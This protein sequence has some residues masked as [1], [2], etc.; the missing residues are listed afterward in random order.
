MKYLVRFAIVLAV[1]IMALSGCKKDKE[2]GTRSQLIG[3]WQCDKEYIV[4]YDESAEDEGYAW[5]KEW[6]EADE[7][8]S[9]L[10]GEDYHGNGWFKW[11]KGDDYIRVALMMSIS[12]AN[13]A[14]DWTL[15]TL[16]DSEMSLAQKNKQFKTYRKVDSK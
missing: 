4:F 3:R 1:A 7:M 2:I 5:G 12:E 13:P 8:E 16:T 14:L 10:D 6:D 11:K 9:D 15:N